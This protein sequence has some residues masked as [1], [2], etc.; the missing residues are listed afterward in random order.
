MVLFHGENYVYYDIK[1]KGT[2][3]T[4]TGCRTTWIYRVYKEAASTVICVSWLHLFS[5]LLTYSPF[6]PSC[7]MHLRFCIHTC[8]LVN[9]NVPG[10]DNIACIHVPLFRSP[11]SAPGSRSACWSFYQTVRLIVASIFK[12]LITDFD[13][14]VGHVVKNRAS[15][16]L[17]L[18]N[19]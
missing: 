3:D 11:C 8:F 6:S 10:T 2:R 16:T 9:G 12:T 7:R 19:I 17:K 4:M 14:S 13:F 15:F 1:Y 18:I 5:A